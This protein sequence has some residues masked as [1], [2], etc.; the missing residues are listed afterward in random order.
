MT[1]DEATL[2]VPPSINHSRGLPAG[3]VGSH[4][5]LRPSF[6]GAVRDK[7]PGHL[8]SSP[9][10]VI[11]HNWGLRDGRRNPFVEEDDLWCAVL[12]A[13]AS[14]TRYRLAGTTS[15]RFA[16]KLAHPHM[17]PTKIRT[18]YSFLYWFAPRLNVHLTENTHLLDTIN[19]SRHAT[20]KYNN[21]A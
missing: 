17:A 1:L 7:Q 20:I 3:R 4:G 5:T 10:S 14:Q 9:I 2:P 11:R 18:L 13:L 8:W 16:L 12:P 15:F 21:R 19:R 6:P